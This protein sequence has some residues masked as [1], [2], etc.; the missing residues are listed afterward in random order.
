MTAIKN[1]VSYEIVETDHGKE[2][3]LEI[4]GALRHMP[5]HTEVAQAI[6]GTWK[7]TENGIL[8]YSQYMHPEDT[9]EECESALQDDYNYLVAGYAKKVY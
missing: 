7:R 9:V 3:Q 4:K 8:L 2:M 5:R 1:I 6:Y